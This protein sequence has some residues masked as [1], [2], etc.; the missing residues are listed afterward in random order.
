MCFANNVQ[1][2]HLDRVSNILTG[3]WSEYIIDYIIYYILEKERN[4]ADVYLRTGKLV[5][6]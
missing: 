6:S 2:K 4:H 5:N 1:T 3:K